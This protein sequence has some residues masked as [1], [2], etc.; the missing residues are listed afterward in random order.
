MRYASVALAAC[1]HDYF[2]ASRVADLI[3]SVPRV[4]GETQVHL[5]LLEF[6]AIFR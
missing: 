5:K 4:D 2:G 3:L 1:R 6:E